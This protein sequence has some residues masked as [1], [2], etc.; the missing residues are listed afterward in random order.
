MLLPRLARLLLLLFLGHLLL[1]IRKILKLLECEG[2]IA[3]FEHMLGL[4]LLHDRELV[5]S[6]EVLVQ[7]VQQVCEE[8]GG[9]L[10]LSTE[11]LLCVLL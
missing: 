4:P 5:G 8:L 10:L 6:V 1:F 7:N 3:C 11:Q 2:E 9:V